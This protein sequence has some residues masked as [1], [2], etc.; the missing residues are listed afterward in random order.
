MTLLTDFDLRADPDSRRYCKQ[1]QVTVSFA[2]DSG[3]LMSREGL[4]RFEAGDALVIGSTGD[5]WCVERSRFD[6]RYEPV[7]PLAHGADGVY[8]NRPLPVHAKQMRE[9]FSALR[10]AGGD[11][12]RG[13][14]GDWLLQYAPGDYGV[15]ENTRFQAVYRPWREA[16]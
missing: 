10:R 16:D 6:A 5:R 12:L 9:S 8:R 11:V 15:V 1:E 3:A 2:V 7:P 13:N 14:A 4:N